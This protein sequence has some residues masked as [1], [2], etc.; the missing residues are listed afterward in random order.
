MH[1]HDLWIYRF[2]DG[3]PELVLAQGSAAGVE[4]RPDSATGD[5]QV[6]VGIENW[7]DPKWNYAS[8]ARRWNVY[9]W[10]EDR[11]SLDQELSTAPVITAERRA[12]DYVRVVR[13]H[14]QQPK[15]SDGR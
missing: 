1:F 8:G 15:Q 2:R 3:K 6:W 14:M 10:N 11:F 13:E 5:P 12:E 9:T 7:D 4:L